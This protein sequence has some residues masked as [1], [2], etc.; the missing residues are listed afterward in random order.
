MS[1]A[2]PAAGD[3]EL[4]ARASGLH[5]AAARG[6]RS[7]DASALVKLAAA[8]PARR[9]PHAGAEQLTARYG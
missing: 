9:P 3:V 5:R 1:R 4:P 7:V 8:R 6:I 2:G